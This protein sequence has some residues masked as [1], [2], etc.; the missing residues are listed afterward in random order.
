MIAGPLLF[1][2]QIDFI[3]WVRAVRRTT[4]KMEADYVGIPIRGTY[5]TGTE[6]QEVI[7]T[8]CITPNGAL[9]IVRGISE[10]LSG[11]PPG[12]THIPGSN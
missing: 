9:A 5:M 4:G 12:D 7:V 2:T 8:L 1:L 10:L 3:T 11:P 6:S